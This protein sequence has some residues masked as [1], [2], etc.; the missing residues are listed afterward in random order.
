MSESFD[1]YLKIISES[2]SK[3]VKKNNKVQYHNNTGIHTEKVNSQL[4]KNILNGLNTP[5]N[6]NGDILTSRSNF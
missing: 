1:D 4:A 6:R 2:N 3:N 5:E